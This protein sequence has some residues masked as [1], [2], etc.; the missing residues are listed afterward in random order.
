MANTVS[1]FPN[2]FPNGVSLNGIPVL[3]TYPG[4]VY[5]VN[6]ETGSDLASLGTRQAPF[7]SLQFAI[8]QCV[9]ERGD[10]IIVAGQH[11]ENITAANSIAVDKNGVSI[12]GLTGGDLNKP[13]FRYTETAATFTVSASGVSI[14]NLHF[15]FAIIAVVNPIIVA[16]TGHEASISVSMDAATLY[17]PTRFMSVGAANFVKINLEAVSLASSGLT[18]GIRVNGA[19]SP[20]IYINAYGKPSAAWVNFVTVAVQNAHV[21]GY[22]YVVGTTNFTKDV[23]DTVTGSTWF[24]YL[25]DGA[26]GITVQGGSGHVLA[27]A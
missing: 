6:S 25:Q 10:L 15:Q 4:N 13:V 3:N 18:E 8:D 23:V 1:N 26:A 20:Q 24:A 22:M 7:A 11:R 2:G 27:A 14:S 17:P 19:I 9:S 16:A 21:T 5:W 12:I